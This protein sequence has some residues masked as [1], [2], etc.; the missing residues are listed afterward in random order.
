MF[1]Y[2]SHLTSLQW[3]LGL[4]PTTKGRSV[5]HVASHVICITGGV[6]G[7]FHSGQL[8]NDDPTKGKR[9]PMTAFGDEYKWA[10]GANRAVMNGS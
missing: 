5:R 10:V 1:F 6:K 2:Y 8:A 9:R 4:Q 3:R 7:Q